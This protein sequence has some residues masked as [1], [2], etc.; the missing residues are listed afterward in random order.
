MK[1]ILCIAA[2]AAAFAASFFMREGNISGRV[3]H[4]D[5]AEQASTFAD[6]LRG[7]K[8]EYNPNG[9]HGPTLYYYA[10]ACHRLPALKNFDMAQEANISINAPAQSKG[11]GVSLDTLRKLLAPWLAFIFLCYLLGAFAGRAAAWWACACLALSGLSCIYAG[12]FVHEI[13]FAAAVF[14]A[15]QFLW[16]FFKTPSLGRAALAGAFAGLAQATKETSVIAFFALFI[17]SA[18]ALAI[19]PDFRKNLFGLGPKKIA[20]SFAVFCA[21]FFAVFC[22]FYSSF[23]S[24]PRGIVDAFLAYGHFAG[25]SASADFREPFWY[26]L[27]LLFASKSEGAWFGELPISALFCAG[28]AIAAAR[29]ARD[30][31]PDRRRAA[32][33]IIFCA[34]AA[35]LQ[36]AVLSCLSYKTPWLLLSPVALMCAPAGYATA[37]LLESR[38]A[39]AWIPAFAAL[40][41][42]GYWQFG[43][44]YNAAVAYPHDPRNPMILSHTVSDYKNL[45]SRIAD[46]ER[47]SDYGADIPIAFVAGGES[48]WPAP[49]DLRNYPNAGFW[50]D[51]VPEN[52]K[53]FEV[54]VACSPEAAE[55]IG[56][57]LGDSGYVSEYF[58]LRK[59]VVLTVYIRRKLFE[60]IVQ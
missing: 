20:A 15:A 9:P 30:C 8:Y 53:D 56:K 46:A 57:I 31:E 50:G 45:L 2:A 36:I 29:L 51:G 11:D 19:L 48:P 34:I 13:I 4:A 52:L 41:A 28:T 27:R 37:A 18:A 12:Y 38:R 10:Y 16:A 23:G 58:G 6:M 42:L 33:Y 43:L 22:A 47:V 60:K 59:N 25:K 1:R 14:A 17:S 26:Y 5:E 44:S 21:A 24:N 39:V 54:V 40:C 32:A 7:G 49:W 35:A 55:K 3:A